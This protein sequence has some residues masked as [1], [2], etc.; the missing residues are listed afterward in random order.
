MFKR[1]EFK[2]SVMRNF[3]TEQVSITATVYSFSTN[4][5][6]LSKKV[7]D[8]LQKAVFRFYTETDKRAE[9]EIEWTKEKFKDNPEVLRQINKASKGK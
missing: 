4:I 6:K 5:A 9:Q 3:G 1:N 2:F 7:I 8:G